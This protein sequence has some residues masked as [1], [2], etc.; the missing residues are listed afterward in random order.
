MSKLDQRAR[1]E[2]QC[3]GWL[4]A[5]VEH[6][7]SFTKRMNDLWGF[8]DLIALKD[9]RTLLIQVTSVSNMSSRR[10]KINESEHK[11]QIMKCNWEILLIGYKKG[12]NGRYIR[13]I[14]RIK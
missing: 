6:Y 10:K 2:L 13:K 1:T 14:E 3:E 9:E 11:Q 4:V 12:K 5:K 7:N 8:G